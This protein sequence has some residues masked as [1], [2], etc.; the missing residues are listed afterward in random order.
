MKYGRY[1]IFF[2]LGHPEI[3]HATLSNDIFRQGTV[4]HTAASSLSPHAKWMCEVDDATYQ[5]R[6]LRQDL[7]LSL[8]GVEALHF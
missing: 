4:W 6:L 8:I 3:L 5:R 7:A 2:T 1:L